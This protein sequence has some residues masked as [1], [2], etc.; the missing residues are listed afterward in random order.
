MEEYSAIPLT[1][2]TL[3]SRG[4]KLVWKK[5]QKELLVKDQTT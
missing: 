5:G 4:D 2:I 1:R 3:V